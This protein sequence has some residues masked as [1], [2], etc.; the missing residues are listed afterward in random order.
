[1]NERRPSRG[2]SARDMEPI[3]AVTR[4]LA[5]PFDLSTM[6]AE[7]V[8]AA[9]QVLNADRGT[10]WLYDPEADELVLQVATGIEA[11]RVPADTGLAGSCAKSRTIINVPDCY[12]DPRFNPETDR[13][14][15]YRT[16]CML[17]LPLVDHKNVL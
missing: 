1:M 15:N 9:K 14:S 12:A 2:L 4:N 17:T 5:A 10:V 8:N 7:V 16:R 6:L 11:V 3:L 13:A